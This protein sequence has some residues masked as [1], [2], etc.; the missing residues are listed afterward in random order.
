MISEGKNNWIGPENSIIGNGADGIWIGGL[1]A[2]GNIVTENSI[3]N[4]SG[5]GIGLIDGANGGILAPQIT[6]QEPTSLSGNACAGCTVEVF[7]SDDMEGE[8]QV[9][10]A[11]GTADAS[12]FFQIP[13]IGAPYPHLT[14]TATHAVNGTSEFSAVFTSIYQYV[15][16]PLMNK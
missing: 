3:Y 5:S 1:T 7:A 6:T 13:F 10:F 8:G 9:Y 14:V 11:K 4:N 15:Y 2:I 16:L 12:G